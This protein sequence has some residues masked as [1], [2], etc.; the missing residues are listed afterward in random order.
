MKVNIEIEVDALPLVAE[1]VRRQLQARRKY[2]LGCLEDSSPEAQRIR[3]DCV[4]LEDVVEA[5]SN[6]GDPKRK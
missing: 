5:L 1:A 4:I 2:M 6:V 3:R